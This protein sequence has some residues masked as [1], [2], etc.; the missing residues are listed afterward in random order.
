MKK[1]LE[2]RQNLIHILYLRIEDCRT[3]NLVLDEILEGC[4]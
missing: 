4:D 3:L 1:V 2:I